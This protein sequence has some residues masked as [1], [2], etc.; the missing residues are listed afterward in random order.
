MSKITG[1]II[2]RVISEQRQNFLNTAGQIERD[3]LTHPDFSHWRALKEIIVITGVRRSGKSFLLRLIWQKIQATVPVAPDNFLYVNFDDEKMINFKSAD[4]DLLLETFY[5]IFKV[6]HHQNI[7]LFFD[8][9]QNISGWEKFLNR[10]QESDKF[11]IFV[12]GSNATLLSKEIS[13]ALTGRNFSLTLYPL[14]FREFVNFK[15]KK[16]L[17]T[18]A[19]H[20]TENRA[21]LKKLFNGYSENGG[22]PEIVLNG[23]RPLLQEYLKNIIYRDIV[24]R[25][26]IRHEFN[27]REIVAFV[28]SNIGV[29][30][31]LDNIAKM[32]GTKNLM[33]V[34]NYLGYLEDSFLF[35]N[36]PR[37]S[38]SIKQQIYNPDKIFT[39]DPGLYHEV[40]TAS[41]TNDGRLLENIV[42]LELKRRSQTIFYFKENNECDFVIQ[43]K[44]KVMSAMQV[45]KSLDLSNRDREINGLL[46]AVKKFNLKNGLILT[47]DQSEVIK[48]KNQKITAMPIWQWLLEK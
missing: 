28:V 23:Y 31:S 29:V 45:T 14:S 16:L 20:L 17:D 9:I 15:N 47:M 26:R 4:F 40:S 39:V 34:K 30:L 11:K 24:L 42:F 46:E 44:N 13:S 41:S 38:Y 21:Q 32:T 18:R 36:L 22:F 48:I 35:F 10:L 8:E 2:K 33:T 6:N 25:R 5:E 37:H 12:T 1:E 19:R 43:G 27:L 7:F 3:I